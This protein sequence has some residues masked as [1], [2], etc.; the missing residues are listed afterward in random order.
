VRIRLIRS[1]FVAVSL[2]PAVWGGAARTSD[3]V[4]AELVGFLVGLPRDGLRLPPA[5]AVMASLEVPNELGGPRLVFPVEFGVRTEVTL[6][7]NPLRGGELVIL[8]GVLGKGRMRV[9]QIRDVEVAEFEGRVSLP[10]GP[11]ALPTA[12]DQPVD[13]FLDGAPTVAV[14]FLLTPRTAAPRTTLRDGQRVHLAVVLGRRIVVDL[15]T[16]GP[17]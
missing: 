6:R 15:E 11:L 10:G 3:E 14:G 17:R 7:V 2:L 5:A 16:A 12:T 8:E 4:E 13:I 9:L 1:V